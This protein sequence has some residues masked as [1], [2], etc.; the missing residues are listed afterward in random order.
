MGNHTVCLKTKKTLNFLSF[1][2]KY[3]YVQ[4]LS[5]RTEHRL[6]KVTDYTFLVIRAMDTLL[7]VSLKA[8]TF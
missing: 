8:K 4:S 3:G 7:C 1:K 5:H 6:L 2:L